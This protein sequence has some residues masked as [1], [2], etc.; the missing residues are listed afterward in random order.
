MKFINKKYISFL[1]GVLLVVPVLSLGATLKAGEEFSLKKDSSIV[2]NL[3]VVAGDILIDSPIYGD[4]LTA[5]GSILVSQNVSGD[6]LAAGGSVTIVGKTGGDVRVVG[7]DI[8]ISDDVGGD[9][10]VAG[11][12]VRVPSGVVVGK[13]VV[14]AG[15]KIVV[16]GVVNGDLRIVGGQADID[17]NIRGDVFVEAD[18]RIVLGEHTVI[19][20]DLTYRGKD[21]TVLTVHESARVA[22]ETVFQESSF[23]GIS[24]KDK[25]GMFAALFGA[26]M[27]VKVLILLITA[28]LAIFLFKRFSQRVVN[29]VVDRP[30]VELL[31]GFLVAVVVPIVIILL[32]ITIIGS[33]IALLTLFSYIILMML[34]AVYGGVVFGAWLIKAFKKENRIVVDWKSTVFGIIVLSFVGLFPF[35]GWLVCAFFFLT[36]I[37]SIS[38]SVYKSLWLNR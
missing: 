2:D 1:L 31:R 32:F 9:L 8:V 4:L 7:G 12:V 30:W 34:G 16:G 29:G 18:D 3:Y 17:A 5:G 22:G 28:L 10:V 20:G 38:N 14:I 35:I 19:A 15:G 11:G 33:T 6:I 36:S 24:D 26:A 25:K 27:A 13:D 23:A 21:E 37:G